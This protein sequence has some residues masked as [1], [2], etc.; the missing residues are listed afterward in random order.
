MTEY[1]RVQREDYAV[2]ASSLDGQK[3]IDLLDLNSAHRIMHRRRHEEDIKG[4]R[5][6]LKSLNDKE[7]LLAVKM[8]TLAQGTPRLLRC[9]S[10]MG[11]LF[12]K[13]AELEKKLAYLT[14]GEIL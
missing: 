10:L 7:A 6:R 4:L 9:V 5:H 2:I 13:K 14:S 1:M 12:E 11:E 8:S 3:T